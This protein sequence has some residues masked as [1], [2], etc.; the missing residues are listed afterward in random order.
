V[1]L[2]IAAFES[3]PDPRAENTRLDLVEILKI[4]FKPHPGQTLKRA[5]FQ[6]APCRLGAV[7]LRMI[8][9]DPRDQPRA[10]IAPVPT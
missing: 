1:Q 7:V 8:T 9:G 10:P 2:F 3:V 6:A 5:K 4:A